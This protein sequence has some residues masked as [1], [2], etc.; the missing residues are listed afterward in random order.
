MISLL[1]ALMWLSI[2]LPLLLMY[3]L[4]DKYMQGKILLKMSCMDM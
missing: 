3:I 2:S 1:A 4:A